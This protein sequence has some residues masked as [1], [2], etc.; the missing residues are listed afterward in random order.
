MET[1]FFFVTVVT[2]MSS[3]LQESIQHIEVLYR[4]GRLKEICKI[5]DELQQEGDIN[6]EDNLSLDNFKLSVL[7]RRRKNDEGLELADSIIKGSK[8]L[9]KPLE[10]IDALISKAR[11]LIELRDTEKGRELLRQAGKIISKLSDI[12]DKIK[13]HKIA[14]VQEAEGVSFIAESFYERALECFEDFLEISRE[15]EELYCIATAI[16]QCGLALFYLGELERAEKF[17]DESLE[18]FRDID[19]KYFIAQIYSMRS[20]IHFYKGE[21]NHALEFNGR[22]LAI[23]E[24]LDNECDIARTLQHM[25]MIYGQSG[26]LNKALEQFT[27][28]KEIFEEIGLHHSVATCINNISGVHFKLGNYDETLESLN[29]YY[30]LKMGLKDE[31]SIG[32]A[33]NRIGEVYLI[34]GEL[35]EASKHF[36][37][38]LVITKRYNVKRTL[39][40]IYFNF[41]ELYYKK[42][43]LE[44]AIK[45]HL[46]SLAIHEELNLSFQIADSL[47]KLIIIHLDSELY[48]LAKELLD[49]FKQL[50]EKVESKYVIQTY[51]LSEALFLKESRK[52]RD[53]NRAEVLLERLIEEDIVNYLIKIEALLNLCD[54]L[55]WNIRKSDEVEFEE[56]ILEELNEYVA[57]LSQTAEKQN[58]FTLAVESLFLQS[59]LALLELDTQQAQLSLKKALEIANE[60][61]LDKLAVK[62]SNEFDVLLDQLDTWEDFTLK[63]PTI[64]EKLELT[65]IEDKLEQIIKRRTVASVDTEIGEEFPVLFLILSLEGTI[66]FSEQF[67]ESLSSQFKEEVLKNVR[68][69]VSQEKTS[70]KIGRFRIKDYVCLLKDFEGLIFCYLFIGKSY[71]G[72]QKLEEFTKILSK[73]TLITNILVESVGSQKSL[74]YDDRVKITEILDI[75]FL[76]DS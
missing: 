20:G 56:E 71:S 46:Q 31:R 25:G 45:N 37:D 49:K 24:E 12:D 64:A 27:R 38:A 29:D 40:L 34:K 21:I 39:G 75:V 1:V 54:I 33:L 22:S 57:M 67:D 44:E 51:Q 65:H 66:T 2:A 13:F 15:T 70:E 35:N 72:V 3:S 50:A 19:A 68:E 4:E 32:I 16:Y 61:S 28:S 73:K 42:G 18:I 63:L 5:I 30:N 17:F 14:K 9:R 7:I 10:E 58:S 76:K 43:N 59:Q 41:G 60:N 53:R 26:D 47:H 11:I 74:E 23:F 48:N 6:P 69:Y 55:L 52:E 8:E 62:I 36:E